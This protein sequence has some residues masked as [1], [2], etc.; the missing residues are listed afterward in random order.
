MEEEVL[1]IM[2]RTRWIVLAA[3]CV[4]ATMFADSI[5][6][7]IF[8]GSLAVGGSV[9]IDKT[10]TITT[11]VTGPVDIMFMSDTTGSMS[12]AISSVRTGVS[13]IVSATSGLSPNTQYAVSAYRDAGDAYVYQLNQ[14]LTGNT[15]LV[16]NA[17]NS[18]SASGGGDYPEAD[19][20]ALDQAATTTSWRPLS[21]R[22]LFWI[23]DAPGHD[24]SVGG[25]T[26]AMATTALTDNYIRTFPI[27]VGSGGLNDY[28][29]ATRI[30]AATGGQ[31]I[32][33]GYTQAATLIEN[34]INTALTTYHS[35]GLAV[36]GL[37]A[38]LDVTLSGGY[39]G[40]W[41]RDA[42]R[43]FDFT[44]GFEGVNP[45]T[46]DFQIAALLDGSPVAFENDSITVGAVPEPAA[47]L[48]F[49]TAL[50]FVAGVAS[51][52]RRSV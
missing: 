49:G 3:L 30:A 39:T 20:Y 6:P 51:R 18:W 5:T 17:V 22:M 7:S 37:P 14:N 48:L 43:P 16:Q 13:G 29:Q 50:V 27:S 23:G 33:G 28:G 44:V 4:P 10:V 40:N 38:G 41:T 42:D 31:L 36:I 46:Y 8:T 9:S 25:V 47:I 35:V 24:P 34:T 52:R 26:E 32:S 19:L 11:G 45:G 15:T 1:Q 12:G 2:R 21:N